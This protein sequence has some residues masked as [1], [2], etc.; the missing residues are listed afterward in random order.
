[1]SFLSDIYSE[2]S[3]TTMCVPLSTHT[4]NMLTASK[5]SVFTLQTTFTC[6]SGYCSKLHKFYPKEHVTSTQVCVREQLENTDTGAETGIETGTEM[7]IKVEFQVANLRI[8][9]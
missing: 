9:V 1:M 2:L 5:Q 7:R 4:D 8:T 6:L 3:F